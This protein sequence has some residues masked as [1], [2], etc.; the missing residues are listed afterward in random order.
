M[1][2]LRKFLSTATLPPKAQVLAGQVP[3]APKFLVVPSGEIPSDQHAKLL[4]MTSALVVGT[5]FDVV[6]KGLYETLST[7]EE[8]AMALNNVADT[9]YDKFTRGFTSLLR[10]SPAP[11][12]AVNRQ[13]ARADVH[14]ELL[15]VLF[16]DVVVGGNSSGVM[17]ELDGRLTEFV[18]GLKA[19]PLDGEGEDEDREL[20][21]FFLSSRINRK[22]I[23]GPTNPFYRETPLIKMHLLRVKAG[24]Y[25][26]LVAKDSA[27]STKKDTSKSTEAASST[28]AQAGYNSGGVETPLSWRDL[29]FGHQTRV[30]ETE[31]EEDTVTLK[32]DYFTVNG[33][34]NVGEFDQRRGQLDAWFK[35]VTGKGL[36]EYADQ[37]TRVLYV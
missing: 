23:G 11:R 13:V 20:A 26:E 1:D 34:L 7:P 9:M 31:E 8:V 37:T 27:S 4:E 6:E 33:E 32:A 28:G 5:A 2:D 16:E 17:K 35:S 36:K 15:N 21:F 14:R 10:A 29:L 19:L 3:L 18:D 22:N 24:I 25:S 12:V 30:E